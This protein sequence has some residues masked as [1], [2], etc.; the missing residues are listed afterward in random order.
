V[1]LTSRTPGSPALSQSKECRLMS[2]QRWV[3]VAGTGLSTGVPS[4]DIWAAR[5]VGEELARNRYGLVTG[6]WQGVDYM[7]TKAYVE[8]LRVLSLDPKEYLIQVVQPGR[9]AFHEVGHVV[10]TPHGPQEWLEPQK[11]ADALVL[12][13]GRG[14][15]FDA[16]L[17]A[18]H[19]GI[20]RFPLGGTSGDAASAFKKTSDLWELIPVPGIRKSDFEILGTPIRSESDA[21]VVAEHLV[22]RLLP[23]AL[24]A[25]DAVSRSDSDGAASLFISY[26]RKDCDWVSRI[27][28]LLRPAERRGLVSTWAD[29][30]I[31]AGSQWEEDIKDRIERSQAALLLMSNDL[32]KSSF[33][34][35]ME[36]PAFVNKVKKSPSQ[37]RLFW[38]L[39]ETCPWQ[40]IPELGQFQSVGSTSQA[41]KD[42][43]TP[44]DAQCRLLEAV[45]EILRAIPRNDP[46]LV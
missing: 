26:S 42:A 6:G 11:F 4:E 19:D 16:W 10:R 29:T 14:G 33:V 45:E 38:L 35:K 7:V 36:I 2:S 23:A 20:P 1:K 27:R 37:F 12:I 21:R 39:L 5:A 18:L 43:P 25:V 17:G 34:R 32:L 40:E 3:L 22:A 44:A 28:T 8:T 46:K 13:G 24:N 15:T 30:D 41:I 9:N 31:R